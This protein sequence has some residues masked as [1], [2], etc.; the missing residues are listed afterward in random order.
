[1]KTARFVVFQDKKKLW[2]WHLKAA[3]GK[4]IAQG[5]AHSRKSDAERAVRAVKA[6]V[7]QAR[8]LWTV[9][10]KIDVKTRDALIAEISKT[11]QRPCIPGVSMR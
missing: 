10:S 11:I 1:M 3:N 8:T 4:V 9:S 6:A 7:Q 5:E 2:R